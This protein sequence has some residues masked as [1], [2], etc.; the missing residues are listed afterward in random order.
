[1]LT[2]LLFVLRPDGEQTSHVHLSRLSLASAER[3]DGRVVS[4]WVEVGKP[5]VTTDGRH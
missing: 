4:V 3:L 2:L 1:M 5:V